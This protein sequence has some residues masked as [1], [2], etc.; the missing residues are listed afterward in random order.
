V[1]DVTTTGDATFVPENFVGL[2]E[3]VSGDGTFS[4]SVSAVD[5]GEAGGSITNTAH[6]DGVSDEVSVIIG[7]E[8]VYDEMTM[9]Y[10]SVPIYYDFPCCVGIDLEASSTV[11][12]LAEDVPPPPSFAVDDYCTYLRNAYGDPSGGPTPTDAQV[13]LDSYYNSTTFPSGLRIG[14]VGGGS[15]YDAFWN[16]TA[17]PGTQGKPRLRTYLNNAVGEGNPNGALTA[18]TTNANSTS[19]GELAKQTATLTLNVGFSDAGVAGDPLLLPLGDLELCDLEEG[20][21]IGTWTLTA[22][23][24]TALNG[25]LIGDILADANTALGTGVLPSY[26]DPAVPATFD[27]FDEL[28][29][30]VTALNLSFNDCVPSGFAQ[31]HLCPKPEPA[32]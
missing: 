24:A 1:E 29:E 11:T 17:T 8:S 15:V 20:D 9:T 16:T 22:V 6:L 13:L 27:G 26:V 12:V 30:L 23:Q 7:Y 5:G 28:N 3:W 32:D 25:Q 2:G 4:V 14:V 31:A 19:G 21:M 18:D 10:N